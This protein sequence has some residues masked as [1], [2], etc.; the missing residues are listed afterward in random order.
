MEISSS[1]RRVWLLII[2]GVIIVLFVGT[3]LHGTLVLHG[4]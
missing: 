3:W 1:K 2:I 4:G